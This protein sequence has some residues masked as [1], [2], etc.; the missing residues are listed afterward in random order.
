MYYTNN[1]LGLA[2][3]LMNG[4]ASLDYN[5]LLTFIRVYT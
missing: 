1:S 5:Y 3:I 2:E 4:N